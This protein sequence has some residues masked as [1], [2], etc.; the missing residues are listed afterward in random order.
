MT[1]DVVA[2]SSPSRLRETFAPFGE[3]GGLVEIQGTA[4]GRAFRR[5]ELDAM[6]TLA[7]KGIQE[8]IGLQR[9]ALES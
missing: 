3:A 7:R 2:S 6:P 5:D 8:L 9:A 4:E 1:A